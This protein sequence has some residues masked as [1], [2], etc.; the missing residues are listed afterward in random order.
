MKS[1]HDI[2]GDGGSDILG[3]VRAIRNRRARNLSGVRHLVAVA[4]GKGGVGKSTVATQLAAGLR[5]AG[6]RVAI[7]DADLNGPSQARLTGLGL[8]PL[9]PI[10]DGQVALPKAANG[11]GVV[12]IGALLPEGEELN[13]ESVA[14]GEMHTWRAAREFTLLEELL[15]TVAWGDLDELV[16][17]LPPGA[18]RA[19]QYA[20]FL[21]PSV[22]FV[23]V[24][25]P[26]ALA[27][28][29]VSR[30][31]AA[32]AKTP[33][34]ILGY[35][36]NMSG[37]HCGECGTVQPLFPRE[38]ENVL[39]AP[40]LGHIPFDPALAARCDRGESVFAPPALPSAAAASI[41][42]DRIVAALEET[43]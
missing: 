14:S 38:D 2:V 33:N 4:S 21:G 19:V 32:L 22:Q 3:Q 43:P 12:S 30:S 16:V 37:Y 42:V 13:F 7:L 23:L 36:E 27:R 11:I 17:D 35:V 15:G 28:G 6:R 31:L 9:I 24:T 5:D 41:L 26:S 8:R 10:D 39:G 18:E 20:E 29:V 34:R 1:Y 40:L 25:I